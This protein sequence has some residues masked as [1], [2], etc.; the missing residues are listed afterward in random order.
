MKLY[1]YNRKGKVAFALGGEKGC[2][3]TYIA[4][5]LADEYNLVPVAFG[6]KLKAFTDFIFDWQS[7]D[8]ATEENKELPIDSTL[9]KQN[10]SYRMLWVEF[11]AICNRLEPGVFIRHTATDLEW[12]TKQNEV[13][14]ITDVRSELE[15]EFCMK[16]DIPIVKIESDSKYK[17]KQGFEFESPILKFKDFDSVFTNT[18]D[19]NKQSIIDFFGEKYFADDCQ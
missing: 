13:S 3:K 11:A 18:K 16:N 8:H 2:G 10:L 6:D 5:I 9:N 19:G 7:S 17:T 4:N 14:I 1:N 15:I 12:L